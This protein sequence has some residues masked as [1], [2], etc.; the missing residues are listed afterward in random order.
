[1]KHPKGPLTASAV[2]NLNPSNTGTRLVHRK[3][4]FNSHLEPPAPQ[5]PGAFE[6]IVPYARRTEKEISGSG[7]LKN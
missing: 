4:G 6:E 2:Q 7:L 1:M 3:F 5:G